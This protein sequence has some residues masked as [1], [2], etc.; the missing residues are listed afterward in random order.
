M[1]SSFAPFCASSLLLS[2]SLFPF[3]AKKVGAHAREEEEEE[4]EE[5][6]AFIRALDRYIDTIDDENN[7]KR[8]VETYH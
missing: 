1:P 5:E 3:C 7:K 8:K 4:E 6:S 2:L